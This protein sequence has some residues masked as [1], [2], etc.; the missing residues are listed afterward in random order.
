MF[1]LEKT[2]IQNQAFRPG[3]FVW[4]IVLEFFFCMD[5]VILIHKSL[6]VTIAN[7]L[8]QL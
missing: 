4:L 8:T 3:M 6:I 1:Y 7:T 5:C 2:I